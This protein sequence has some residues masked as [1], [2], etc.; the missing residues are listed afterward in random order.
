MNRC[1]PEKVGTKEYGKMMKR[2]QVLEEL[3]ERENGTKK[4][5]L[6]EENVEDGGV[7]LRL[8]ASWLKMAMECR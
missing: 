2:I 8:D 7:S 4:E 6:I 1:Q 5:G 3:G